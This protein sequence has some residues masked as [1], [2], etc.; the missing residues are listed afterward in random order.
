MIGTLQVD[1]LDEA[2]TAIVRRLP[3]FLHRMRLID[4]EKKVQLLHALFSL[5]GTAL[6]QLPRRF[7]GGKKGDTAPG[8]G[9][10]QREEQT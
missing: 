10:E 7:G 8:D 9:S 5:G 6:N 2:R 1:T 4:R 3:T